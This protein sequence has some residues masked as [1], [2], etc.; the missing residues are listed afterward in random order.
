MVRLRS[1]LR[2]L[3][4]GA[5]ALAV[6]ALAAATG[7]RVA[8]VVCAPGFP[9]NT[10]QAKPTMDALAG[11]ITRAASLPGGGAMEAAYYETEEGGIARLGRGDAGLALVPLPFYLRHARD[12][13]LAPKLQVV[14]E[15]GATQV[16]SLV[17]KKGSIPRAAALA[18]WEV[19]GV[20]GYAPAFVSAV[21]LG[22]WGSL[23]ADAKITFTPRP[24]SAL[25][26]AAAGEKVAVLLDGEQT[27]A[28]ASLP[29]AADLEVVARSNSLPGTLL[30]SVGDRVAGADLSKLLAA[31]AGLSGSP[32]GVAV[33]KELRMKGFEPAD[34]AALD[35]LLKTFTAPAGR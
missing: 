19:T 35:A 18:R 33:L 22:G 34:A 17:A 30:C 23:P 10:E 25:R 15:K 31:L 16:W 5:L 26:R 32:S 4:A 2:P 20:P 7:A 14:Q 24:L 8:L 11:E 13:A 29:F 27:D 1:L 21:A 9:G 12:L 6:S 3:L 28:L